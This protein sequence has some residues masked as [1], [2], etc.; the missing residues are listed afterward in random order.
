MEAG[1]SLLSRLANTHT[2]CAR[3]NAEILAAHSAHM[4]NMNRESPPFNCQAGYKDSYSIL[5]Q[6]HFTTVITLITSP[7]MKS[8]SGLLSVICMDTH[9][10]TIQ[11]SWNLSS[12][13]VTPLQPLK[14]VSHIDDLDSKLNIPLLINFKE[15]LFFKKQYF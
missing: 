2:Q 9:H 6:F 13:Y 12:C 14:L 11:P 8:N 15:E 3:C 4:V 5:R 7:N 10:Y 1:P